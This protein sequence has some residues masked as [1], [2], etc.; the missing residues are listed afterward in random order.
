MTILSNIVL[1]NIYLKF[2]KR[3]NLKC[4]YH[5]NKIKKEKNKNTMVIMWC[6]GYINSLECGDYFIMYTYIKTSSCTSLYTILICQLSLSKDRKK[7]ELTE[8]KTKQKNL[9]KEIFILFLFENNCLLSAM[10]F[11]TSMI[12]L[13]QCKTTIPPPFHNL[14]FSTKASQIRLF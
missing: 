11:N 7:M 14:L 6:D 3:V 13:M 5:E 1:C 4:S 8:E 2:A 12:Q 9:K 10:S